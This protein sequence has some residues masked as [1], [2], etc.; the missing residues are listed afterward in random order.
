M[1]FS[2]NKNCL[3]SEVALTLDSTG[4]VLYEIN[5]DNVNPMICGGYGDSISDNTTQLLLK[6][7][8]THNDFEKILNVSDD[9]FNKLK[10]LCVLF[11]GY[12]NDFD[13]LNSKQV[14]S[15]H[16]SLSVRND[17]SK[18]MSNVE[19]TLFALICSIFS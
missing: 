11:N 9:K 18:R 16:L 6:I 17:L 1:V 19:R 15:G 5:G 4:Y 14:N 8:S 3:A 7:K 2:L 12:A 13:A 10:N